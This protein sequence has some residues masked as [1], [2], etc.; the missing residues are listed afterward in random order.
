M[1]EWKVWWSD[2]S[3]GQ[4]PDMIVDEPPAHENSTPQSIAYAIAGSKDGTLLGSG[5]ECLCWVMRPDGEMKALNIMIHI[6]KFY[7]IS[8]VNDPDDDGE[9]WP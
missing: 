5:D 7:V 4:A 6:E 8:D 9:E 1:S 2:P 3:A